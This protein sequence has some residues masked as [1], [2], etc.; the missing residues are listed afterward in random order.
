MGP[1]PP[2]EPLLPFDPASEAA[3]DKHSVVLTMKDVHKQ[4]TRHKYGSRKRD[5]VQAAC[6][7]PALGHA[8]WYHDTEPIVTLSS[9]EA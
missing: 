4:G 1:V 2:V 7:L 8:R 5:V 9:R 3:S 6:M